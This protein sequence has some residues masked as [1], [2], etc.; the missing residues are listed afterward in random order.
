MAR[1]VDQVV[2]SVFSSL[3]P[4]A[5]A[6]QERSYE[7]GGWH[8]HP[9]WGLSGLWHLGIM[10]LILAFWGVVIAGVVLGIRWL[11]NQGKRPQS[12]PA[13]EIL[14]QRYARGD[15]SKDEFE[16]KKRDLT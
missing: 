7:W 10:L 11:G 1:G 5:V 2:A 15:I 6:A 16:A 14:R 3:V 8:V 4:S 13:L 12:D 9:L